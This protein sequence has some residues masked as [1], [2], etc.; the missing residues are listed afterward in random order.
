LLRVVDCLTLYHDLPLV[1]LAALICVMGCLSTTMVASRGLATRRAGPWSV[2]IGLSFGATA[3]STHFVAMLAY[4]L[5]VPIAYAAWPT[6]LSLLV[7]LV[8]VVTGFGCALHL[9]RHLAGRLLG[10]AAVGA[11]VLSLHY[12]GMSGI[13]FPGVLTYATDL[14]VLSVVCG[15]GFGM[16]AIGVMFA[17]G[18]RAR[19]HRQGAALLLLMVVSLHFIG[20]GAAEISFGRVGPDATQGWPRAALVT[21][22]VVVQLLVLAIGVGA[23]LLDRRI[24]SHLVRLARHDV[25]TGLPNRRYFGEL[26]E[27]TIARARRH[28]RAFAVLI[29]DLDDFKSINDMYGH[30]EGDVC[31]R[32]VTHRIGAL[33]REGD[34]LARLGGDEFA[35]IQRDIDQAAGTTRQLC[36]DIHDALAMPVSLGGAQVDTGVSI[37]MARYPRDGQGMERLMRDAEVALHRAK[38]GGKGMSVFFEPSMNAALDARRRLEARL[39]LATN[40]GSFEVHYQPLVA[41]GNRRTVCCEALL[42]WE[43]EELGRVSP[44]EFVPVAESTGLIV[45]IGDFVLDRACRDAMSWPGELRVAVNLSVVQFTRDGLVDSV[46]GALARSGLPGRRLELEITE[47]LL[48]DDRTRVLGLLQ[49]LRTLGVE[50][51]M[52]DFG[53]GYSS[54]SYLQLFDFSKLKIDRSFVSG[55]R[56]GGRD[57]AIVRAAIAMGRSLGMRVV[58]EGVETDMQADL[59]AGLRCDELQGYLIARP[60]TSAKMMVFLAGE[61]GGA[62]GGMDDPLDRAA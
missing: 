51:A 30:A 52:D 6:V 19:Q 46:R 5:G 21:G 22:V 47:S 49:E 42:R 13:R 11:G 62:D 9:R 60:M 61:G 14:V 17:P 37:G 3:W 36:A 28:D 31:I 10:G 55:I 39:R 58:A 18:A 7:G 15:L 23:A 57:A 40:N 8:I 25:L 16:A 24:T 53:T 33:L 59:L 20:M 45:P 50:I 12:I 26:F 48:I 32:T 4:R 29:V 27:Q 35:L 41:S 38:I 43:D 54:L 2:L 34:V 44:E 1:G 56:D